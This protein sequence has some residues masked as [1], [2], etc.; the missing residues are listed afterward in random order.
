MCEP[1]EK[2]P[3]MVKDRDVPDSMNSL[4]SWAL[5]GKSMKAAVPLKSGFWQR[6]PRKG[7][8]LVI[9]WRA[10]GAPHSGAAV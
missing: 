10:Y 9:A 3:S 2:M 5:K 4:R 7:R 6:K 8:A 1:H